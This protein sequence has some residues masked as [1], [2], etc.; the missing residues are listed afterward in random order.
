MANL[1]NSLLLKAATF[2]RFWVVGSASWSTANTVNWA[3]ISGGAGGKGV[4]TLASPVFFDA[5]SGASTVTVVSNGGAKGI[6]CTGFT[7]TL[8]GATSM[9]NAGSLTLNSGMGYTYSGT[10]TFSS[11]LAGNTITSAGKS[12]A[13]SL[14]FSGIGG[15]WQ[16]QDNLTHTGLSGV[17]VT[18]GTLD[19]NGKTITMGGNFTASAAGAILAGTSTATL[20]MSGVTSTT[21]VLD[22]KAAYTWGTVNF[23]GGVS[24]TQPS[25]TNT[26]ADGAITINT[27]TRS[28]AAYTRLF[29]N[30][31]IVV[32]T[33]LTLTGSN[34]N[35]QRTGLINNTTGAIGVTCN[36]AATLTN[37]DFVGITV[38]GSAA[39]ISG[40]SVGDYGGNSGI[41][42]TTPIAR[43]LVTAAGVND[44]MGNIYA[45]SSGGAP[46]GV[47]ALGQDTI[48][49]DSNSFTTSGRSL[50][51][52]SWR[53]MDLD[54][55][56]ATN[57]PTLTVSATTSSIYGN[58]TLKSGMTASG[59]GFYRFTTRTT[60]TITSNGVS[61]AAGLVILAAGTVE[62]A[63]NLVCTPA[64]GIAITSGIFD[65][66]NHDI[67]TTVLTSN[68]SVTAPATFNKG[69][70]TLTLTGI[71]NVLNFSGTGANITFSDL[72]TIKITNTGGSTKNI[73]PGTGK[74]F[75]I[76]WN[77][78]GTIGNG[79]VSINGS[80]TIAEFKSDATR[81][82]NFQ[83]SSTQTINTLTLDVNCLIG[84]TGAANYT[85]INTSGSPWASTGTT[86]SKCT[87]VGGWTVT[88]GV[89][90][91][92]NSGITFV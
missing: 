7:G 70:G 57:N 27:L 25:I 71:N 5:N 10:I 32:P 56:N 8:A 16:L 35:T 76:L 26:A 63:D 30:T 61:W 54:F 68:P 64:I 12:F 92:S 65:D 66:N 15:T 84:S 89:D 24:L 73:S 81:E 74:T 9:Q 87:C 21:S 88:G 53:V 2:E 17:T 13:G 4:P 72:G 67:T 36:G 39:P 44:Y 19:L 60:Q 82:T 48:T 79:T 28:N 23:T 69:T 14:N 38:T 47:R 90:G 3:L 43:Y 50:D 78:G 31:P 40:T 20:I 1:F 52:A 6:D 22:S 55:T 85:L 91:G 49:I 46:D 83:A 58:V 77:A 59:A 86:V 18:N 33:Q 37:A 62:L 75:N 41:T 51:V 11:P 34:Q 45:A 42:F 29:L 80:N